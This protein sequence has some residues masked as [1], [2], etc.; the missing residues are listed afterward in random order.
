MAVTGAAA[1][2][3]FALAAALAGLPVRPASGQDGPRSP[4]QPPPLAYLIHLTHGGDPIVVGA[5]SEE[6]DAIVFEKYGGR[7]S[8]PRAEIARIVRDGEPDGAAPS[9]PAMMPA[10]NGDGS[11]V[12][13]AARDGGNL[14]VDAIKPGPDGQA[15]LVANGGS[16][17]MA[18]QDVLAILRLPESG[19]IPE[20]WL[21]A[22]SVAGA[23]PGPAARPAPPGTERASVAYRSS[24]RPHVLRLTNGQ[25]VEVDG[26]WI[27][28]EQLYYP[29]FG[30]VIGLPIGDIARILPQA[31]TATVE[32]LPARFL[33]QLGPGRMLVKLGAESAGVTLIGVKP[34]AGAWTAENPWKQLAVDSPLQ[35]ELDRRRSN[36]QGDLLAYAFLSNGR[37]LNAEL[38]RLGLAL[39]CSDGTNVRYLDLFHELAADEVIGPCTARP[40]AGTPRPGPPAARP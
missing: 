22:R 3:A 38:L 32:R 21:F 26:F 27:E 7:V 8:I 5:Y 14:R 6:G 31:P 12:L 36:E 37:M 10:V 35:L 2:L 19:G 20:A 39:P 11:R 40:R 29:R 16:V 24:D 33:E 9:G 30:G 23:A 25:L 13:V 34:A 18:Q 17:T 1:L 28:A 15:R 4:A